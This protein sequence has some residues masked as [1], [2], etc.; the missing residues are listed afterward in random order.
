MFSPTPNT[1]FLHTILTCLSEVGVYV[2]ESLE[3]L[4]ESRVCRC[5][6]LIWT[7]GHD[8]SLSPRIKFGTRTHLNSFRLFL[9]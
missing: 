3:S 6:Y 7:E 4:T 2:C 1:V 9:N 5:K 8:D